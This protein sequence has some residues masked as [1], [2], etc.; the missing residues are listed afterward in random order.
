M[1]RYW[2]GGGSTSAW[3]AT[4]N[5]NWGTAS[6]TRD[7]ASV[8][9]AT[10]DVIFDNSVNGNTPCTITANAA[11]KTLTMTG[12]SN[13]ITQSTNT[14]V[15]LSGNA[16]L[17]GGM[18][19]TYSGSNCAM[20]WNTN[21]SLT[22]DGLQ[23]NVI[24]VT[25]SA[26]L[27][28]Q[29]TL[30][31]KSFS[32]NAGSI[33]ANSQTVIFNQNICEI[34]GPTDGL[35][36]YNLTLSGT[37]AFSD[38]I[39]IY[40]NITVTN[41][42]VINES[43]GRLWVQSYSLGTATTITAANVSC[44]YAS[45][46]DITGAGAGSWN[47][48]AISGG[49]GDCG[50][51]SGITFTTAATQHWV[52]TSGG[53]WS[54]AAN[55]TSRVPLPQDDVEIDCVFSSGVSIA[56]DVLLLGKS[57]DWSGASWSGT[58]PSVGYGSLSG[59]RQV[60]GDYTANSGIT[61]ASLITHVFNRRDADSTFTS[62]G[63]AIGNI[64]CACYGRTLF[65]GDNWTAVNS[66]FSLLYGTL[67]FND[68]DISCYKF[69]ADS[70]S[71]GRILY[72]GTG[73][74]TI[75]G[76]GTGW[77]I[78]PTGLTINAEQSTITFSDTSSSSKT[79]DG[80]SFTYNNLTVTGSGTGAFILTG[81]NIFNNFTIN[82]PKTVQFTAGTTTY[83][84]G[85]FTATGT[86]GNTITITSVTAATHTLS[87]ANG[88]TECDYLVI[89]YSTATGGAAWYAGV[90]STYGAGGSG[91]VS[92]WIF[93]SDW[94]EYKDYSRGDE[95]SLPSGITDLETA[96]SGAE[97]TT[98][99]T[100]DTNRVEQTCMEEQYAIHQ[101]KDY[102]GEETA[103]I[104]TWN[105]QTNTD[106]AVRPVYL[107]IYKKSTDTWETLETYNTSTIDSDFTITHTMEDLTNYVDSY[108]IT[109][110]VYQQE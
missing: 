106:P 72:M 13:T 57:I 63:K 87:K 4:G 46:M 54:T 3:S 58:V 16:V 36:F 100:D 91:T 29:D 2:V 14:S 82:A 81:S 110:R 75:V 55:W 68:K 94:D 79:F 42:F 107:Q 61:P 41:N 109:C 47:L 20:N 102:V 25:S 44:A 73:T 56:I 69:S 93:T 12:W 66:T 6:N 52:N 103:C 11:A 18:T 64:T 104:I 71:T 40:R 21:A 31:C 43:S 98:V 5:T 26:V 51:N 38:Y 70:S 96:Y 17:E 39:K 95:G 32:M 84:T 80:E 78:S 67:D 9:S 48:S 77:A 88:L 50:G 53:D 97:V 28:L 7:N 92:G 10:D 22:T 34:Y 108:I 27:T 49:S 101:F 90:N 37:G 59:T 8:P 24:T 86:A 85:T 62:A 60:F 74:I 89:D 1:A 19:W 99:S 33:D 65:M 83:I 23:M 30:S 105:G 35:T 45:F 15:V 76:T